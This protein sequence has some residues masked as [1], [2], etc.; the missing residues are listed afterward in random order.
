[1]KDRHKDSE[2]YSFL[3]GVGLDND[4]GHVRITKG[5]DFHLVGGSEKTH[6]KM[7]DKMLEISE[8]LARRGKKIRD[9][10]PDDFDRVSEIIKD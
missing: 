4:D 8:D 6:Y 2:S 5:D 7:Q 9:I 10:G 3:L 1:M